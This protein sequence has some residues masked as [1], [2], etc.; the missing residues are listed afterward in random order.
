MAN[1]TFH[2][3]DPSSIIAWQFDREFYCIVD[4][5]KE[6]SCAGFLFYG[7]AQ[8]MFISLDQRNLRHV[9]LSLE[10]F[11]D[12]FETPDNTQGEMMQVLLKWLIIIVTR[13]A[14]DRYIPEKGIARR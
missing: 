1:E 11:R 8:K 5:D 13:L 2:F 12:E 6:V 9:E 4:Q 7:S 10:L 14:K 3:D